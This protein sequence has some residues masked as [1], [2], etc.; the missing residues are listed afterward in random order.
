[1]NPNLIQKTYLILV[2]ALI[3][4]GCSH[5]PEPRHI[6]DSS[7][8]S[9]HIE[10]QVFNKKI[11]T[12]PAAIIYCRNVAQIK[13][14]MV[15]AQDQNYPIRIRS[16]RHSYEGFSSGN[17][18][19][20]IDL[21]QFKDLTLSKDKK[22]VKL[23]A[24]LD[25]YT[26]AKKLAP[27]GVTIPLGSC[28]SV[29]IAGL[30]LG[31]G[32][33]F[34]SR[35]IGLTADSLIEFEIVD[36]EGKLLKVNAHNHPNLFWAGRGAGH[37][38]FGIITSF[39][40]KTHPI[41]Q[42]TIYKLNMDWSYLHPA[43]N[44]WFNIQKYAPKELMLFLRFSKKEGKK[45][46]TTFGQFY[47]SPAKLK[48]V[49]H[50]ILKINPDFEKNIQIEVMPYLR[51]IEY[52][53]GISQHNKNSY[54]RDL[55][56]HRKAFKAT[57]L[58]L[59]KPFPQKAIE[60]IDAFYSKPEINDNFTVLDSLGGAIAEKP[61]NFNAYAHRSS[62]ASVQTLAYW[63]LE[64]N[65]LSQNLWARDFYHRL[66]PFGKGAYRNYEDIWLP[67]WGQAYYCEHF[68]TLIKIKQ[69]YDPLNLFSYPQSIPIASSTKP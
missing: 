30:T 47:G 45:T 12:K 8:P 44:A 27:F 60:I 1:M 18:I 17:G 40:F 42:V 2:I 36:F 21:S 15:Y 62:I 32:L 35:L 52:W 19:L 56:N 24:G 69:Q 14:A 31:G 7:L 29:G 58:L 26:I 10:S 20:V 16:G 59:Q 66:A 9:Y 34:S 54:Q 3:I 49:L 61:D 4:N 28:P 46:L 22:T 55:F 38:S 43:T 39:T 11:D 5:F 37:G 25:S 13:A 50:P 41:S 51:A 53:A 67:N 57:S 23:G 65:K 63:T 64:E 6:I 48:E 33:G 68:E